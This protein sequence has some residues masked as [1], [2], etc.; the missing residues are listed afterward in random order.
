MGTLLLTTTGRTS[1]QARSVPVYFLRDGE[2][3]V[4]V[5]SNAGDD[6]DPAWYLNLRADPSASAQTPLGVARV[7]A[8]DAS[9]DER[10]R[11]WPELVEHNPGFARYERRTKR[12]M[13]IVVLEPD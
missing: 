9:A 13:P 5:A 8:R 11:L 7:H 1:G 6:R 4:L 10:A 3:L 2:R 12:H